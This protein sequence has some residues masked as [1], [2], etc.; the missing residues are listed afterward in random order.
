[1]NSTFRS[2]KK[3]IVPTD[4]QFNWVYWLM[5]GPKII[6]IFS[7][8]PQPLPTTL[9]FFGYIF[10]RQ[11]KTAISRSILK[12]CLKVFSQKEL[13]MLP[14]LLLPTLKYALKWVS[15]NCYIHRM[16]SDGIV[17]MVFLVSTLRPKLDNQISYSKR[18]VCKQ[19]NDH[20]WSLR[21]L[22]SKNQN[23]SKSSW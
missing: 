6:W 2:K 21:K 14:L 5:S 20:T 4:C 16:G 15:H 10:A 13:L 7:R 22:K 17:L 1:M 19:S 3:V 23:R 11:T 12:C 9:N 18:I 8:Y